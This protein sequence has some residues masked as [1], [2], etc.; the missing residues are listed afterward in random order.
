VTTGLTPHAGRLVSFAALALVAGVVGGRVELVAVGAAAVAVLAYAL[1]RPHGALDVAA[2]L[3]AERVIEGEDVQVTVT[4]TARGPIDSATVEFVLGPGLHV[5]SDAPYA[6]VSLRDGEQRDVTFTV[7]PRRWGVYTIGPFYVT[8]YARARTSSWLVEAEPV[9]VRVLPRADE[10]EA[11]TAHPFTRALSGTHV[12]RV[13]GEGVEPVGVREYASGD[14]LRR[15]NWR[16]TARRG[17]LHVTEQRPERNAEV[18]LFLDTFVET[19]PEGAT[20]LDVAVRAAVGI[21]EHYLASMDRVGVVGFGGV[22][23]WLTAASGR[24]QHYRIVEHL[25][26][27]G[28]VASYAAKD[29]AVLPARAL[30]PRALVIALSPLLDSRATSALADLARRGFGL[31]VVDTSPEP[32]LPAATSWSRDLAQRV[33][34]LERDALLHRFGEVGVPVVPWAGPGTLDVVLGEVSR[35]HAR[36]RVSLR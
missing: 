27:T 13:S 11:P 16:V 5:V 8:A 23:R 15:V 19:G 18:V 21:A 3:D 26:G 2:G 6:T 22:T 25:L 12:A 30:P 31:V 24:V 7:R 29:I 10:F 36:P 14:S 4:L 32:L 34:L 35:L 28:L 20:T 33:W 9:T 17:A 1:T